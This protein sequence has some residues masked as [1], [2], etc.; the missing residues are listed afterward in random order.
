[1][2]PVLGVQEDYASLPTGFEEAE[3]YVLSIYIY[4]RPPTILPGTTIFIHTGKA[5]R[6]IGAKSAVLRLMRDKLKVGFCIVQPVPI[7]V[8][9]LLGWKAHNEPV[10]VYFCLSSVC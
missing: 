8:A 4:S 7:L 1:M 9:N 2:V 10:H 3:V 6:V 5:G